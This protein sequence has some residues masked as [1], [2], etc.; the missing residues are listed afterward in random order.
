MLKNLQLEAN[1]I[2]EF[3][4]L[5]YGD[6]TGYMYVALK[7]PQQSSIESKWKQH[8]FNWPTDQDTAV[9]FI[10]AN[11]AEWEVFYGPALYAQK[12]AKKEDV[13]GAN[14]LWVEFDGNVP[15]SFGEIPN[16]SIRVQSSPGHEHCYWK[17]DRLL[18]SEELDSLN[19]SLTYTFGA[20][21]S[22]W[23]ATQILRPPATFNH[24]RDKEV[25]LVLASEQVH[26]VNVFIGLPTPPPLIPEPIPD[27]LPPVADAIS[28]YKFPPKCW[29]L[30]QEG[31]QDR[32]AGLMALGYYLAEMQMTVPEML[33]VLLNADS[34]WGKF[35]DRSDQTKR[36]MEIITIAK[37]KYPSKN[38]GSVASENESEFSSIGF[39][40]LLTSEVDIEW[41]LE[42]LLH[43]QG[44]MLTTGPSGVGKSTFALGAGQHFAL[45][46][47]F[48]DMNVKT[49]HRIGVFSLEMDIPEL[50]YF[51]KLQ[52]GAYTQ[53]ELNI[54]EENFRIFP[55]GEPLY[56]NREA[57]QRRI[58]QVVEKEKL[59]GIIIDSMGSS[60]EQSLSDELSVKNLVDWNDHIRKEYG[61]FTWFIHHHRKASGDNKRP[62]K[63]SDVY[64]NQYITAR[65]T[66]VLCLWETPV[67]NSVEVLSLKLRL[68]PKPDPFLVYKDSKLIFTKKKA[69]I[70]VIAS[71][72]EDEAKAASN[73]VSD[74]NKVSDLESHVIN[75]GIGEDGGTFNV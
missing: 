24:K 49:R 6:A 61:I 25:I 42:G 56:M 35:A 22:G 37:T 71:S 23:D 3:L 31:S 70:T 43:K 73:E 50:K 68:A 26:D 66:S 28:R 21:Q 65:A 47:N 16:P 30:F 17:I 5:I 8:W 59:D 13:L 52:A 19:R 36:L 69:G 34:R 39:L 41:V 27:D 51:L 40:S 9:N 74:P 38:E 10:L 57:E 55:L 64:G 63:L 53:E 15:T 29:K 32:S 48:L 58:Q 72:K 45:G 44:Y 1:Q 46:K 67:K 33:S 12:S 14:V 4:G 11:R 60:T 75:P 20:D 2:K 18:D 7:A 54:L 62:N